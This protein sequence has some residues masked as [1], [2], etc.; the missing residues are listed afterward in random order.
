MNM[1]VRELRAN[2]IPLIVWTLSLG[3]IVMIAFVEYEAFNDNPDI[4][5]FMDAFP[6]E[7]M[8]AFG[9]TSSNLTSVPGFT[10]MFSIYYYLTLSIHAGLLGA[11]I[12]AKEER[13]KTAEFLFT[14]PVKRNE[15]LLSKFVAGVLNL[16][17]F[18]GLTMVIT[19]FAA[20]RYDPDPSYVEFLWL[21]GIGLFMIQ[22]LFFTLGMGLSSYMK[23][24]KR[25]GQIVLAVILSTWSISAVV[26]MIEEIE[27]LKY[28]T[29]FKYFEAA[30]LVDNMSFEFIYFIIS[31]VLITI[32]TTGIFTFYRKR[33]LYI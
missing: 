33:D 25:P 18:V 8:A 9:M 6:P 19:Y 4:V 16:L 3:A 26:G 12:L 13:D 21:L 15:V 32:F 10:S 20:S 11:G 17:V 29:P 27:F 14:L 22:L 2:L 7:M 28:V 5:A 24:S 1:L 30:Y 31:G 23:D